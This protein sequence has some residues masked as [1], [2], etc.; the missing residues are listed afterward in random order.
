MR[1]T[2]GRRALRTSRKWRSLSAAGSRPLIPVAAFALLACGAGPDVVGPSAGS[3]SRAEPT[4]T[5]DPDLVGTWRGTIAGGNATRTASGEMTL[6]L[7]DDG[8]LSVRVDHSAYHP[9]D[10]GEWSVAGDAFTALGID[11]TGG[12]VDFEAPRSTTRLDG[13]W[14][15]GG[16]SGTFSV[17]KE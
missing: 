9:I 8:S 1:T 3:G 17:A 16:G 12:A 15:S 4:G 7:N 6:T 14:S 10:R 2:V 13:T 5:V 11:S